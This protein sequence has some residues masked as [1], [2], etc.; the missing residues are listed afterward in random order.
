M[1][2]LLGAVFDLDGLLVDSEGLKFRSI[3]E[4]LAGYGVELFEDEFIERWIGRGYGFR[5]GIE[6]HGLM[7]HHDAIHARQTEVYLKLIHDELEL[8]PGARYALKELKR[9]GMK[10]ALATASRVQFMEA[11]VEKF[12]LME[13]MDAVISGSEITTSKPDPEIYLEAVSRIG[14]APDVCVAFEDSNGGVESAKA[15]GLFC[16]A[17]PNRYTEEMDLSRADLSI[18]SLER[19]VWA[20]DK[21]STI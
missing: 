4:V 12:A 7:E 5:E 3:T 18:G 19:A 8:M 17:V 13:H 2:E 1:A 9:R 15:A 6:R 14:L 21:L 10:L 16:V 20:V 11:T